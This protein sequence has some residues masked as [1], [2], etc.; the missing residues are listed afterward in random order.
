MSGAS[1]RAHDPDCFGPGFGL[2]AAPTPAQLTEGSQTARPSTPSISTH[3]KSIPNSR[4]SQRGSGTFVPGPVLTSVEALATSTSTLI[5]DN[6]FASDAIRHK[7]RGLASPMK[8]RPDAHANPNSESG[9][10]TQQR[11]L[12]NDYRGVA[13]GC[14]VRDT[15]LLGR[16]GKG[17]C[18][19]APVRDHR[20]PFQ[21]D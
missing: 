8:L 5:T 4:R 2:D 15:L 7:G 18:S 10:S 6:G 12:D 9:L 17:L 14:S 19:P 11:V 16:R 1:P 21:W 20:S 13:S 3:D